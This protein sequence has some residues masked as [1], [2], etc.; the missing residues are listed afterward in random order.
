MSKNVPSLRLKG[1]N[2]EWENHKLNKFYDFFKGRG[3][4][5]NSFYEGSDLPAI[6][7]GHLYT[8]YTETIT[9]VFLSSKDVNGILSKTGDLL[10]PGSSTVSLGTAQASA[11]M[12]D[13]VR[14]GGDIIVA[15]DKDN[16][17]YAP[18]MSHQINAKKVKL[19][20]IIVGTT[21]THMYGKD[22]S[23]V[24]YNFPL[25][26]EQFKIGVLFERINDLIT[27]NQQKYEK[28]INVKKALLQKMFV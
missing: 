25:I 10:F 1:F 11:I 9:N 7:Y 4:S 21:I 17:C 23:N 26:T 12:L 13:G 16:H 19:F 6:S 27:L 24:D 8:H 2:D 20:P 14:L 15:R 22:I 5:S 18:F 28:L 3:Q